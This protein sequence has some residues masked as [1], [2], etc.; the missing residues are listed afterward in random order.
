MVKSI[1]QKHQFYA[2]VLLLFIHFIGISRLIYHFY[3]PKI[4][5]FLHFLFVF[6][7]WAIFFITIYCLQTNRVLLKKLF[8]GLFLSIYTACFS[9]LYIGNYISLSQWGEYFSYKTFIIGWKSKSELWTI[10]PIHCIVTFVS[11]FLLLTLS[12]F[13]GSKNY[14]LFGR[15]KDR[16]Y[17][18]LL[19]VVYV[20]I[21][22]VLIFTNGFKIRTY[23]KL[24]GEPTYNFFLPV[25]FAFESGAKAYDYENEIAAYKEKLSTISIHDKPNII[26]IVLDALR[27]DRLSF[28]GYQRETT[29]FLDSLSKTKNFISFQ[30]VRSN[31]STSFCGILSILSGVPIYD[32]KANDFKIHDALKHMGYSTHFVL[33]GAHNDWYQLRR[34]YE[35]HTKLTN[36]HEGSFNKKFDVSDDRALLTY[37]E[38]ANLGKEQKH[39]LYFHLMSVHRSAIRENKF[40]KYKPDKYIVLN[41]NS[42]EEIS[43]NYDNGVVQADAYLKELFILL[44]KKDVLEDAIVVITADHGEAL[45]EH[46]LFGHS[47]RVYESHIR[48]PLLIWSK[49][50]SFALD[51]YAPINQSDLCGLI[52]NKVCSSSCSNFW[53]YEINTL[54]RLSFHRQNYH[55]AVVETSLKGSQKLLYNQKSDDFEFFDISSDPYEKVSIPFDQSNEH[56]LF[57]QNQLFSKFSLPQYHFED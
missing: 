41:D 40:K 51:E 29:P 49:N 24:K 56:H 5:F 32:L 37:V 21:L 45:G 26:L 22:S 23:F 3:L 18:S 17:L 14:N 39:F 27:Y 16:N 12:F 25:S 42:L 15:L 28:N 57:L 2:Y 38:N 10:F 46:E 6:F 31:C 36:Y 33:S 7:L 54:P 44:E 43:N 47:G 34:A 13:F 55:Y 8:Y 20:S 53:D 1:Y 35:F 50:H 9:I 30:N 4:V 48:I 19:S 52:M 11:L